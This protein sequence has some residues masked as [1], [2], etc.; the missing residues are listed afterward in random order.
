MEPMH[1]ER[2]VRESEVKEEEEDVVRLHALGCK[3]T[4][5]ERERS[6]QEEKKKVRSIGNG[7]G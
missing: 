6:I 5:A 1:T 7:R 2:E 3:V 4:E